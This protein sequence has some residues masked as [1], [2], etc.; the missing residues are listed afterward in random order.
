[1]A[2][3]ALKADP[4]CTHANLL[5]TFFPTHVED[6][7]PK[8][9]RNLKKQGGFADSRL[10]TQKHQAAWDESASEDAI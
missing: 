6:T 9:K 3:F 10:S 2:A 8:A 4:L 1:M 7:F 5:G